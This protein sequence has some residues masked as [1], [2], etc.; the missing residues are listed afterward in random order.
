MESPSLFKRQDV[1]MDSQREKIDG[2]ALKQ[3][4][5][6]E[7]E[8]NFVKENVIK[9]LQSDSLMDMSINTKFLEATSEHI[10]AGVIKLMAIKP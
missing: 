1:N 10:G 2:E 3:V 5:L 6:L 8:L 4:S 7:K 9:T